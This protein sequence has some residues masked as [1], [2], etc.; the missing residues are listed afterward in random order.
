MSE[1]SRRNRFVMDSIEGVKLVHP[2]GREEY[3]KDIKLPEEEEEAKVCFSAYLKAAWAEVQKAAENGD[4]NGDLGHFNRLCRC[5]VRTNWSDLDSESFLH[6]YH[7]CVAAVAH[8]ISVLERFWQKQVELF[9]F[10]DVARIVSE[11][12]AIW[13]EWQKEKRFLNSRMVQAVLT[14]SELIKERGWEEF[15]RD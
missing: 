9:R 5:G 15:K 8:N 4:D 11:Q 13:S 3:V 14:T 12:E 10:H 7:R 1:K 6:N 2:D